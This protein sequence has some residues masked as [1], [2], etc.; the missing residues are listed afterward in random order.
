MDPDLSSRLTPAEGRTFGLSVGLA[1]CVL[2]S[3]LLWRS[4]ELGAW[5]CMGLGGFLI[6]AGLLA[7]SRMGPI[8]AGWMRLAHAISRVTTPVFMALV[9]FLLLTPTGLAMRALGRNPLRPR[10]T[11]EEEGYWVRRTRTGSDLTRQF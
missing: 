4:H 11:A 5:V 2:A 1:F 6:L 3:V 8:H 10:R 7:P 9:Y